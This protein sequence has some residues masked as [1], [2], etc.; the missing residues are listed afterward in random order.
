M[1][2][3]TKIILKLDYN[4]KHELQQYARYGGISMN[5]FITLAI[6]K[7]IVRCREK[8]ESYVGSDRT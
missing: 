1:D 7:E 5:D 3:R 8:L 2:L 4:L 6:M